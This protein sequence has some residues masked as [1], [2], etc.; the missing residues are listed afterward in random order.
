MS[1]PALT[2]RTPEGDAMLG[3]FGWFVPIISGVIAV[4]FWSFRSRIPRLAEDREKA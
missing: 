1:Y 2:I 3:A 4:V